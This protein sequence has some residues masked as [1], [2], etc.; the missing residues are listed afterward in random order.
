MNEVMSMS[1]YED[2]LVIVSRSEFCR[3]GIM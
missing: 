3:H 2:F 1:M